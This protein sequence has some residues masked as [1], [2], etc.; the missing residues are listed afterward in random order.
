MKKKTNKELFEQKFKIY[1]EFLE[2]LLNGKRENLSAPNKKL[3]KQFENETKDI[4]FWS[5]CL[6][7]IQIEFLDWSEHTDNVNDNFTKLFF[8]LSKYKNV[9]YKFYIENEQNILD[10]RLHQ[11]NSYK[12]PKPIKSYKDIGKGVGLK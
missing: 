5:F 8:I 2:L 7:Q 11:Q 3:L 12:K 6:N 9:L 1:N 4:N 10:L